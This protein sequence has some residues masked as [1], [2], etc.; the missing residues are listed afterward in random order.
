MQIK[1]VPFPEA[2]EPR[3]PIPPRPKAVP[4]AMAKNDARHVKTSL[5]IAT[6]NTQQEQDE[7]HA[8]Y[9]RF[10]KQITKLKATK[11]VSGAR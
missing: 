7:P 1:S 5:T 3:W 11:V 10:R 2:D 6:T 9:L 8:D 4:N